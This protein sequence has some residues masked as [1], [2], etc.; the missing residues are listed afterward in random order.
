MADRDKSN[1]AKAG[2]KSAGAKPQLRSR[3]FLSHGGA[4]SGDDAGEMPKRS[5]GMRAHADVNAQTPRELAPPAPR[6]PY[7]LEDK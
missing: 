7:D 4:P 2:V 5:R 6:R 3:G 1:G